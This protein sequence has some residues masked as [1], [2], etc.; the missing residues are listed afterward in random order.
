[1]SKRAGWTRWYLSSGLLACAVYLALP[2]S[3]AGQAVLVALALSTPIVGSLAVRRFPLRG[4][5]A[6]RV[7]VVGLAIAAVGEVVDFICIAL[8]AWPDAGSTIDVTFLLAYGLQLWGL[9]LLFRAQTVSGHQFGWF[10]AAAVGVAVGTVVW[11]SM[12]DAIFGSGSAGP[13]DWLTRFVGSA[14]GV[15]LVVMALLLVISARGRSASLNFLLAGFVVQIVTDSTAALWSGY[16]AGG[17]FDVLWAVGY[18]LMGAGVINGGLMA[19]SGQLATRQTHQEIKHTLVLQAGVT[20]VLATTIFIEIGDNV[21]L[22][23]LAVW[24]TAWLAIMVMTRVRVFGLLRMVTETSATVNQRRLSAMVSSSNDVIGLADHDGTIRYMTP[25]I[26]RLTGVPLEQWIGKRMDV[27][28]T[29]HMDGLVDFTVHSALLGPGESEQWECTVRSGLNTVSRGTVK[30]TLAN[31]LDTPDV[32]GWVITA[33]DITEQAQL[34]AELRHQSLHDTLTGLPNRGLLFDRIQHSAD[35]RTRSDQSG[36]SLVLVDIDDFKSFNDNL[37]HTTGDELL[38]AV[39]ERLSASVRYGDT[40]A[41]LDGDEFVILLEGTDEAEAMVLAERALESLALPVQITNGSFAVRA[42]AGVVCSHD[43][44][45]PMELLR[46]ADVAMYASKRDG[47]SRVTLFHQDMHEN[48]NRQFELRMDLSAALDRSQLRVAYQPI[49]DTHTNRICGAEA[50]L[51][52]KHPV[53][54]EVSPAEF[55]PL[56]EQSGQ[57][58]SIG[59]WVLRTACAEAS[60]WTGAGSESYI[61]VNVSALQLNES[62]ADVVFAAL[63]ETELPAPRL[64]LEITESMLVHESASNRELLAHLRDAGI[65]IAIDDF[66]TGFSSLA[67]L[68]SLCVDVVKVDRAFVRDVDTN[69]DHQALTRTI[70]SL[71]DGFAMTAIAEGVETEHELAELTRL[72]CRFAQGFLFHRPL[73]PENLRQAFELSLSDRSGS[74]SSR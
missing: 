13:L 5:S 24:A 47:K 46:S 23:S 19:K 14:L 29:Q 71:A 44:A 72:G 15:A 34:T 12:Y 48:A 57:I 60:Q 69:S 56:A 50:L 45:S 64:M 41:R 16:S 66:G 25:S 73:A 53:L 51:R 61:S 67:Y 58:R 9:M 26:E 55:I 27:M 3:V 6:W 30:L 11:S 18:L 7:L 49:L 70:L 68:Q 4:R 17:R 42:S 74:G 36:L 52:W 33:R 20:I 54:G 28:L 63:A 10:D 59:Q 32:N 31:Q 21:V 65:R 62:F 8:N 35:L 40:V 37:G 39:A 43:D 2:R 1:M 22:A 38:R